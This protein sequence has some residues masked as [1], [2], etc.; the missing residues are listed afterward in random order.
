[1]TLLAGT[2][3]RSSRESPSRHA[4]CRRW[5]HKLFSKCSIVRPGSPTPP[6]R[7]TESLRTDYGL[8]SEGIRRNESFDHAP[9]RGH[10]P[11]PN[12]RDLLWVMASSGLLL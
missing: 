9:G 5:P 2:R 8:G 11:A 6:W 10:R 4:A 1:M 3:R 12:S 7:L